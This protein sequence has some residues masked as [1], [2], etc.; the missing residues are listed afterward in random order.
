MYARHLTLLFL[1]AACGKNSED[2][3]ETPNPD[4]GPTV[5]VVEMCGNGS[6]PLPE[7]LTELVMDDGTA[8]GDLEDLGWSITTSATYNLGEEP[9]WE[10]VRFELENPAIVHGFSVMWS[11]L[12]EDPEKKL[13]I[14]LHPDFGYNGFDFW[15]PDPYGVARRCVKDV[16]EG[17]WITYTL[18][19]PVS[20]DHPGLVYVAHERKGAGSPGWMLD[21]SA[22]GEGDC[23][24]FDDCR[25]AV[26]L[27]EADASQ[28]YNG[29]SLMIPYDYLVRLH[30]E[31]TDEVAPADKIFQRIT[32]APAGYR[33]SW[34]DFDDDGDED[35]LAGGANLFRNDGGSFTDITTDAGLAGIGGS[36]T[37]W[38]DYDNDGCLDFFVFTESYSSG[39]YLL[40][41]NCDGTFTEVTAAAG[42]DDIQDYNLCEGAETNNHEP[43]PAAAWLDIDSDGLLDLY[44]VNFNCW[45]N[46]SY[47]T[48]NVWHNEGD[49]TFTAWTGINGFETARLP[50]RGA[51]PVDH[52]GDGD[53][54]LLV[55]SYVL[56]RNMMFTNN[57]DG[58]V[59]EEAGVLGLAGHAD[60]A[61]MQSYYGH[62]IGST[63]GDL[64]NDG[65]FDSVQANLAHPRFYDFSDRTQILLND[66]GTYTDI[67][68]DWAFPSSDA[69]L[70]YQ[71]THSVPVLGDFDQD[72]VLDLSI[73]AVYDG[74]PTDFYWG[75]G[76][77]TF[78]L[79]AYHAGIDTENGWGMSA[80]DVDGDGDLDLVVKDG[81]FEN[82]ASDGHWLQIRPVGNVDSNWAALGATVRV[83][84]GSD[85][86]MRHVQGGNAQG[87]QDPQTQHFGLG[88]A[89]T[90]DG[91]EIDF[92][93]GGT[94]IYAGP[95]DAD[96][97]LRLFED[98]SSTSY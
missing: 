48:D 47:Y 5:T 50:G 67:S 11:R 82:T 1:V 21:A 29:L 66:A 10:S 34:A 36:G 20:I 71:E 74:R 3:D 62:T 12:P 63:W 86:W 33:T 76:D 80:A 49:G 56:I 35:V 91:I 65:D 78:I 30:V 16:T 45:D 69:G 19:E 79:D 90:I 23:G 52:D 98:G 2:P 84:A 92:P 95:F 18:E 51:S 87:C 68:G 97:R 17:E 44:V 24:S 8:A 27:P 89:T 15:A 4:T 25:S 83:T 43:S 14:G 54:D 22:N 26:N 41:S 96:Q 9:S 38:G 40:H 55:H 94:V 31:Y 58:T 13:A 6:A 28:Y 85:T 81:M 57:G 46:Y 77:G 60:G 42:I 37:V 64:D 88:A 70:R 7:G 39:D 59:T 72:G 75:V 73:S 32:D 53:V 61:G 93:G